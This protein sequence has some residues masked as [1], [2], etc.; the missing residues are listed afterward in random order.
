MKTPPRDECRLDNGGR[1]ACGCVDRCAREHI[2]PDAPPTEAAHVDAYEL[3]RRSRDKE[4]ARLE[5]A[6]KPLRPI[7]PICHRPRC[8]LLDKYR[9]LVVAG[10]RRPHRYG[11]LESP[12]TEADCD[13]PR[14]KASE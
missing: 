4:V 6:L 7:C 11:L 1:G 9:R 12:L 2:A 5:A 10:Y 14:P 8:A 3:G 13:A